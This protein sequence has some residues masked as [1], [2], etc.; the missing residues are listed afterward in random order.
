MEEATQLMHVPQRHR[1]LYEYFKILIKR[2]WLILLVFL[3]VVAYTALKTLRATPIY[4]ATVQI[5]IERHKP[6]YIDQAGGSAQPDFYGEE[7][8]HTHYKLL[9]TC[10]GKKV[11]T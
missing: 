7:F 1:T 11:A 4:S 10:L 2:R 5:L 9:E 8:Y 3:P 6:Q